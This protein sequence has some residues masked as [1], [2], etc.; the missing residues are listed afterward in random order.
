MALGWTLSTLST[1]VGSVRRSRVEHRRLMSR[2][3]NILESVGIELELAPAWRSA[4]G[5]ESL[6][7]LLEVDESWRERIPPHPPRLPKDF[8]EVVG[9]VTEW[10]AGEGENSLT[11]RLLS[12]G[13]SIELL[14][15]LHHGLEVYARELPADTPIPERP[16][17]V[18]KSSL[19]DLQKTVMGLLPEIWPRR[20]TFVGRW[21][22][23]IGSRMQ[24][25]RAWKETRRRQ[26]SDERPGGSDA[27]G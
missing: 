18:Y 24:R 17:G 25:R 15:R 1:V 4:G 10:E 27:R 14:G 26:K 22:R 13:V 3:F 5:L 6:A 21:R 20:Y 2:T 7:Q 12:V 8:E 23:R 16:L 11:R 19:D 9:R